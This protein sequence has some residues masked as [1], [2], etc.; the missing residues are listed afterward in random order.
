VR[1]RLGIPAR[2]DPPNWRHKLADNPH[3]SGRALEHISRRLFSEGQH[4]YTT[5][6]VDEA[7]RLHSI[8]P[9]YCTYRWSGLGQFIMILMAQ[10]SSE[11]AGLWRGQYV[12]RRHAVFHDCN[13]DEFSPSRVVR[14][15]Y[16]VENYPSYAQALEEITI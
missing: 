15:E 11:A 3:L 4:L 2:F 12:H 14:V 16:L 13:C 7:R 5:E 10:K 9:H 6:R 8:L 1:T